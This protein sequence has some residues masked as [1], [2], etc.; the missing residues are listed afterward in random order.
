MSGTHH[1]PGI[2]TF[3]WID[4]VMWPTGGDA[5]W[6]RDYVDEA[7][8]SNHTDSV[9]FLFADGSVRGFSRQIDATLRTQQGV[10]NDCLPLGTP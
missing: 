1:V 6:S 3:V 7:Y 4:N 10:R 9:H 8:S 2:G 5:S